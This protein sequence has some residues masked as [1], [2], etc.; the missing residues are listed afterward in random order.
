MLGLNEQFAPK[1][2]KHSG[3]LGQAVRQAVRQYATE[4]RE[5]KYPAKEHSFD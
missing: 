2:L 1:F 4:V 5:G 3:D